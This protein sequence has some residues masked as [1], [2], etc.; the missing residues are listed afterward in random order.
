[1][2][3]RRHCSEIL[4]TR[5]YDLRKEMKMTEKKQIPAELLRFINGGTEEELAEMYEYIHRKFPEFDNFSREDAIAV[6][7]IAYLPID[8]VELSNYGPA[9]QENVFYT[10]DGRKIGTPEIMAMLKEKYGE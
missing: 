7:L 5:E 9:D 1:M 8:K 6:A 2:R 10:Y 3:Q 4:I